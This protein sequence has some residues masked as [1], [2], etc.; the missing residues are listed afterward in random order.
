MKVNWHCLERGCDH[1]EANTRAA[2]QGNHLASSEVSAI[3]PHLPSLQILKVLDLPL[4][5]KGCDRTPLAVKGDSASALAEKYL[6]QN[7]VE[8]ISKTCGVS[9]ESGDRPDL[10]TITLN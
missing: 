6:R 1:L 9:I 8:A 10:R 2:P 7:T 5:G 3:A 4:D